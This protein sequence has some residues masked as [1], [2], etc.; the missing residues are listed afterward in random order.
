MPITLVPPRPGKTPYYSGRGR[1]LGIYIDRSTKTGKR[2]LALKIIAK[3]EREIER[4]EFAVP[5]RPTFTSAALDYI[6]ARRST[7]SARS[8]ASVFR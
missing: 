5:G 7:P 2:A 4:G 6:N 8:L 3:W 1:Y